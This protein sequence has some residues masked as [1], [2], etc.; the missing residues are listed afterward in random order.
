MYRECRVLSTAACWAR[1]CQ[2]R[3]SCHV[4]VTASYAL[5]VSYLRTAYRYSHEFIPERCLDKLYYVYRVPY[6]TICLMCY[7]CIQL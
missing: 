7:S 3:V 1:H 4:S 5:G 2:S 6:D